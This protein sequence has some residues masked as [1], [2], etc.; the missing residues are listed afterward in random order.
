MPFLLV[1]VLLCALSHAFAVN[2]GA[3]II[4]EVSGIGT[5]V[6]LMNP[7]AAPLYFG[8]SMASSGAVI[9]SEGQVF[10]QAILS[11]GRDA[12]LITTPNEQ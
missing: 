2:P 10:F 7:G 5:V 3:E 8:L 4:S 6:H 9:N 12:L 11:D 1:V